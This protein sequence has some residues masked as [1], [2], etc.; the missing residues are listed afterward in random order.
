MY[1][2]ISL[3]IIMMSVSA[4]CASAAVQPASLGDLITEALA[5]NPELRVLEAAVESARGGVITATLWQNPEVSLAPGIKSVNGDDGDETT[6][7]LEAEFVQ[8]LRF[9]G[10]RAVDKAIAAG[11]VELQEIALDVL[12]WQLLQN[13][14]KVFS[15]L[16]ATTKIIELRREQVES[17]SLFA[18]AAQRRAQSGYASDFESARSEAELIAAKKALREAE[19]VSIGL[20]VTLNT[21]LGRNATDDLNIT[22]SLDEDL[23]PV[24]I[25]DAVTAAASRNPTL[26]LVAHQAGL[27]DLSLRAARLERRPDFAVGPSLEY[28]EEE[29]VLGLGLS[30]PLPLWDRKRGVIATATAEQQKALAD[31]TKT[32]AEISGAAAQAASRY[33]AARESAALY[34]PDFLNRLKFAVT[35]AE[36]GLANNATTLLIYLDAKKAYFDTLSEYYETLL[37]IAESRAD[38]ESAAGCSLND[39]SK[40]GGKE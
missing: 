32:R 26:R 8:P 38:L 27:A 13:V 6:F 4:F 20:R 24:A 16:L 25:S 3:L 37:T 9:P 28:T 33:E 21:L 11:T 14:R 17:S 29:Q 18:E 34:T 40:H 15:Q 22:G 39:L 23:A 19:A 5:N 1:K 30:L 2:K 7:H 31:L 35:Q 10:K 12:R 36:H